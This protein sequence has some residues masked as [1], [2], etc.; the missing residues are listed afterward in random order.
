MPAISKIASSL[1]KTSLGFQKGTVKPA[2]L[3]QQQA[4]R[5]VFAGLANKQFGNHKIAQENREISTVMTPTTFGPKGNVTSGGH[6]NGELDVAEQKML[7]Q[8]TGKLITHIGHSP[9]P[10]NELNAEQRA[11][12]KASAV[13]VTFEGTDGKK[14]TVGSFQTPSNKGIDWPIKG[15]VER[16]DHGMLSEG[17]IKKIADM[18]KNPN[19]KYEIIGGQGDL[20]GVK[21][22][23]CVEFYG[24]VLTHAGANVKTPTGTTPQDLHEQVKGFKIS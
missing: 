23:N 15:D 17:S 19:L 14:H 5:T 7:L 9:I 13:N 2:Q 24:Q 12:R 21:G 3:A 18:I 16:T 22:T 1:V 8:Q 10:L 4:T 20:N 11:A 6:I